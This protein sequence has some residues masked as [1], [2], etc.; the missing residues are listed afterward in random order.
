MSDASRECAENFPSFLRGRDSTWWISHLPKQQTYIGFFFNNQI[1]QKCEPFIPNARRFFN[2][3]IV[4]R[5]SEE[6]L[7]D[8]LL[9]DSKF[10]M[11]FE[12]NL[13]KVLL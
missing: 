7:Y 8:I 4:L 2:A 10:D 13:I 5:T 1:T 11:S 3:S 12:I 6:T 9:L